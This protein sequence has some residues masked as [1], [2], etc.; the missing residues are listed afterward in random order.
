MR[1]RS[2]YPR[3][4]PDTLIT[5]DWLALS[6]TR[7]A[8][9]RTLLAYLRTSVSLIGLGLIMAKWFDHRLVVYTGIALA[10][11][12][13]LVVLIGGWRFVQESRRC[14]VTAAE[15]PGHD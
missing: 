15:D 10:G 14:R 1:K 12:G 2:H 8:N 13:I 9:E 4:D 5:R 3:M 11:L 6:R 7:L